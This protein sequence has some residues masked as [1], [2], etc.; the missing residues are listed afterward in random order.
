MTTFKLHIRFNLVTTRT[1]SKG[2]SSV[3]CRLTYNKNRKDF[4][5]GITV[6]PDHWDPKKQRLLDQSDQEEIVNMQLSL[7]ENKISKA[8][9]ML[10]V[11]E[12][13][14]SVQDIFDAYQ[15]KTLQQDMGIVELWDLHIERIQK[16][17]GKE[18]QWLS[19]RN[20][21]C[22]WNRKAANPSCSEEDICNNSIAV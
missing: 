6:N 18:I 5:T 3:R 2:F 20:C 7:I 11:G 22:S 19:Q 1:N 12:E 4:S 16:L 14:F 10:Q 13:Q 17:I 15:G 9:L 21:R 8:F